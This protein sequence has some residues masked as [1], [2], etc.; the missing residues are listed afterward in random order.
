[1]KKGVSFFFF[2]GVVTSERLYNPSSRFRL[3]F[4]D[5][6]LGTPKGWINR[7]IK[8]NF[9]LGVLTPFLILTGLLFL[10]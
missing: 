9:E 4:L 8:L 2:F 7:L 3:R 6:S 1:M 10:L 5:R